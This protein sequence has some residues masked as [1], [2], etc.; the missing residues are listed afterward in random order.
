MREFGQC[1]E[2]FGIGCFAEVLDADI[3]C[4]IVKHIGCRNTLRRY[5]TACYHEI[6]NGFLPITLYSDLHLRVFRPFQAAHGLFIG[7]GFAHERFAVNT[8]NLVTSQDAGT[9]G[10]PILDDILHVDGVLSDGKFNA[11]TRERAFQVVV[12]CL[13]ILGIDIDRVRVKLA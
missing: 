13:Y 5:F 10:R 8:H 9:V 2:Q 6:F 11:H 3:A 12:G 4:F 7:N 1:N